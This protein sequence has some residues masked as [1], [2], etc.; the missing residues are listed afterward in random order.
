M[1][2]NLIIFDHIGSEERLIKSYPNTTLPIPRK[3]EV[4]NIPELS[5]LYRILNIAYTYHE[6][7]IDIEVM[8]EPVFDSWW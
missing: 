1:P 5:D 4:I 6:D 3:G 7:Y 8:C 2:Y